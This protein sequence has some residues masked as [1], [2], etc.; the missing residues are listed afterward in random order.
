M[1]LVHYLVL[2]F[3]FKEVNIVFILCKVLR[4]VMISYSFWL[5]LAP[6]LEYAESAHHRYRLWLPVAVGFVVG[7][8]FLRLLDYTVPHTHLSQDHGDSDNRKLFEDDDVI[9]SRNHT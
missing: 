9:L 1:P 3:L 2:L 5:L 4:G 6:A 7:G 8:L